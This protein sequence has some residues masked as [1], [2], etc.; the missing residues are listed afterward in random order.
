MQMWRKSYPRVVYQPVTC[1]HGVYYNVVDEVIFKRGLCEWVLPQ[2]VA[3]KIPY[4]R[5]HL[6]V[7]TRRHTGW[8]VELLGG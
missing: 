3:R 8:G 6:P 2:E 4:D 7:V 1:I 5:N